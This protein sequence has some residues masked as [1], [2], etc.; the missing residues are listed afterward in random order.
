M[1]KLIVIAAASLM[2]VSFAACNKAPDPANFGP[3]IINAAI[4]ANGDCDKAAAAINTY[5]DA[6]GDAFFKYAQEQ[7]KAGKKASEVFNTNDDLEKKFEEIL[8][9]CI[10]VDSFQKAAQKVEDLSKKVDALEEA[11]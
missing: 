1:K 8:M 7:I 11:K 6:N 2:L 3:D 4:N 10:T 9:K 5:V